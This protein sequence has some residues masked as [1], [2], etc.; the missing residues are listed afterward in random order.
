MNLSGRGARDRA[1]RSAPRPVRNRFG[2]LAGWLAPAARGRPAAR[3]NPPNPRQGP[4]LFAGRPILAYNGQP[5]QTTLPGE[6]L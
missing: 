1:T 4:G 5:M 3:A 2:G 6:R